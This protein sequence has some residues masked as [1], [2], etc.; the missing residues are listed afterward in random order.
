MTR[1]VVFGDIHA[2]A[3]ALSSALA[4]AD[5]K[6]YDFAVF[7]GDLLTY[8]VDVSETIDLVNGRV[9]GDKGVLL[10]GN[11]DAAYQLPA[12]EFRERMERLPDWIRE[13]TEWTAECLPRERWDLLPFQDEYRYEKILFAHANPFGKNRWEYL[14]TIEEYGEATKALSKIGLRTGIFGHTHRTKWYV[15]DSRGGVFRDSNKG[16][17]NNSDINILNAGAI[18]QPR[19]EVDRNPY[20]LWI[21]FSS[22]SCSVE[23]QQFDY[24][25]NE[26]LDRLRQS[27][28]SVETIN[29]LTKYY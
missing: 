29:Q 22:N 4:A 26:H 8:G 21:E 6:G 14:N 10:R 13:S 28:F 5:R 12:V 15:E 7:L 20:L 19:D 3:S 2:N 1:F 11:H 27:N 25:V 9:D 17:L 24:S 16:D 23:F 18:G